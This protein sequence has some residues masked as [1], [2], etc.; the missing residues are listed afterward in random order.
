M[1]HNIWLFHP[2]KVH[3]S[4]LG[5]LLP[6]DL[7]SNLELGLS[8]PKSYSFCG[9]ESPAAECLCNTV[10]TYKMKNVTLPSNRTSLLN[11]FGDIPSVMGFKFC[12]EYI[13]CGC[14]EELGENT[15]GITSI[16]QGTACRFYRLYWIQR[17]MCIRHIEEDLGFGGDDWDYKREVKGKMQ[18]GR[19]DT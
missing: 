16:Y 14:F 18:E 10:L 19:F 13:T 15:C 3:T 8:N 9:K 7:H 12:N 6:F 5:S 17:G 11:R 1:Y 2:S 4:A